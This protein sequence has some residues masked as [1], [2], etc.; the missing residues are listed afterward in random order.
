MSDIEMLF[1][2]ALF[3]CG[4]VVFKKN[5]KNPEI[6]LWRCSNFARC[7]F[8]KKAEMRSMWGFFHTRK[9]GNAA[10]ALYS[11]LNLGLSAKAWV[12]DKTDITREVVGKCRKSPKQTGWGKR[13]LQQWGRR[14][15]DRNLH[16]AQ[17]RTKQSICMSRVYK[18]VITSLWK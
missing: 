2:F 11:R 18:R 17:S 16:V 14:L 9:L 12:H 5:E 10:Y 15:Y 13:L 8:G 4:L 7:W 6:I 1:Q 3:H